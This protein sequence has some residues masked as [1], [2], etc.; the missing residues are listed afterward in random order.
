MQEKPG[1]G[2]GCAF[3][4]LVIMA[5][6]GFLSLIPEGGG[7]GSTTNTTKVMSDNVV[8]ILSPDTY[9]NWNSNNAPTNVT[10]DRNNIVSSNGTKL[11]WDAK[12]NNYNDAACGGK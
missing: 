10:G 4:V 8:R 2:V 3:G 6:V 7:G 1:A 11:C 5:L 9:V 12:N